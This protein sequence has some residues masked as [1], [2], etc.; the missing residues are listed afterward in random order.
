VRRVVVLF[1]ELHHVVEVRD[2]VE[3]K[4]RMSPLVGAGERVIEL[5]RKMSGDVRDGMEGAHG[6]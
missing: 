1:E 3:A 4:V 5:S 2:L 6:R